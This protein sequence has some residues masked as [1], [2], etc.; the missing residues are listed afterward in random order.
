LRAFASASVR[1]PAKMGAHLLLERRDLTGVNYSAVL[2]T[3][4]AAR[5]FR[6][7]KLRRRS[8]AHDAE[9]RR[10]RPKHCD[11]HWNPR[12]DTGSDIPGRRGVKRPH[13]C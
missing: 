7:R 11:K 1:V 4:P 13:S 9:T 2:P 5:R 8:S 6:W 12:D 10:R 3:R